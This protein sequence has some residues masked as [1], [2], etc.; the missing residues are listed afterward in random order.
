MTLEATL[1]DAAKRG[2]LNHLSI[3]GHTDRQGAVTFR[4]SY[5]DTKRD[6]ARHAE[7]ADPV[8]A[9]VAAM[10]GGK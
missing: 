6:G 5:R 9:I 10:K 4:V 2:A 1:H 7:D 3:I 8:K